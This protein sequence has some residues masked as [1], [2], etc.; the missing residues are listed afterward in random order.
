[1]MVGAAIF[2]LP[3]ANRLSGGGFQDPTS[4]SARATEILRDRFNQTDQ[5]M[6][7]VVS[8]P[9]GA[10]SPQAHRVGTDIVDKL[11]NSPWVMN[12]SS[13]WTSPP[14]AAAQLIS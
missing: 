11:K 14:A 7:I 6:L 5:Q 9:D 2:G 10:R 1:V 12:V 8:A 13:A 4:E 3:V